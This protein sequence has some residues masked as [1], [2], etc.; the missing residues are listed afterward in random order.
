MK[1]KVLDIIKS[2]RSARSFKEEQVSDEEIMTLLEAGSW[3][4]SGDN[5]QSWHFTAVQ[6]PE[7]IKKMSDHSKELMKDFENETLRKMANN[8]ELNIFYK[9]P[10]VIVVSYKEGTLT[11]VEDIS[12]ASQIIL[13]QAESMGLGACWNG[14][15]TFTLFKS[16]LKELLAEKINIPEGYTPHHAIAVGYPKV[17]AVNPPKRKENYFNFA[18]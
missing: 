9:A 6:N 11:P 1:N 16:E 18:K 2:R 12:A 10:T 8:P 7:I 17:K 13:L 14:I 15:V 3:S 5:M 4:P